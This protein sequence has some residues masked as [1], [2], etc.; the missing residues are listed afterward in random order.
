[1]LTGHGAD[2]GVAVLPLTPMALTLARAG[3]PAADSGDNPALMV[4]A[5]PAVAALAER[6]LGQQGQRIALHT[7]SQ[8]ALDAARG[9]WDLAQFDLSSTSSTRALR[10]VGSALSAALYAPQWRAARWGAGVLVVAHLVGLNAWAWQ[11]R[12]ALT[13]KQASVRN[14]LTQTFP[15]CRWWSMRRCRWSANSPSCGRLPAVSRRATWSPCWRRLERPCPMAACP[16]ASNTPPES[17]AC[18]A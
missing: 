13:A 1:M 16:A 8:R 3:L 7:T 4:R 15:K 9:D 18:V 17:C 11:E 6:T 14:T 5:E 10:K 2:Q 12:Q